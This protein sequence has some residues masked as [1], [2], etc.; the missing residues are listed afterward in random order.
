MQS[1][2]A[3][4]SQGCFTKLLPGYITFPLF[5]KNISA[6]IKKS[7]ARINVSKRPRNIL[8]LGVNSLLRTTKKDINGVENA[9][10]R[11]T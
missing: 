9:K 1:V 11:K 6:A 10:Y 7:I 8:S 4:Q 3:G 2:F 5:K